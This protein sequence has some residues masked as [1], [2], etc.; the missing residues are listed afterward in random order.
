MPFTE[1]EKR[2]IVAGFVAL[3]KADPDFTMVVTR[4]EVPH[5]GLWLKG[6]AREVFGG[7]L[8]CLAVA[9]DCL[10]NWSCVDEAGFTRQF[11]FDEVV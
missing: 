1:A 5:A 10:G 3:A 11:L 4:D 8:P 2:E 6:E 7:D 9:Q